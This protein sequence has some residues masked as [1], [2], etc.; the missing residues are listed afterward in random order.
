MNPKRKEGCGIHFQPNRSYK[1]KWLYTERTLSTATTLLNVVELQTSITYFSH[2]YDRR[3]LK[4]RW[5][6]HSSEEYSPLWLQKWCGLVWS[7]APSK[8][9][10][11]CTLVAFAFPQLPVGGMVVPMVRGGVLSASLSGNALTTHPECSLMPRCSPL[12]PSC[13]STVYNHL[14]VEKCLGAVPT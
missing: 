2:C 4:E 5:V 14:K 9:R 12:Q 3:Q 6:W 13:Q 11:P 7:E 1:A 8:K 10:E